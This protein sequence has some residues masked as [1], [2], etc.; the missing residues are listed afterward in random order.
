MKYA[1]LITIIL[2]S[3]LACTSNKTVEDLHNSS[4]LIDTHNDISSAG[5]VDGLDLNQDLSGKHHSDFA[6]FKEGGVDI[7]VFSI[8]MSGKEYGI[9]KAFNY[10]RRQIDTVAAHTKRN[11]D[12]LMWVTN[13]D[14]LFKAVHA[15]KMGVMLGL[16]GGY[17]I[18]DKLENLDSLFNWGVRY[19]TLTWN[20]STSWATSAADE[21]DSS[22]ILPFIGLTDFGKQ[23]VRKMNDLGI[24]VDL[25]HVGEQAFYDAIET[26]TKPVI[27]SHSCVYS[28]CPVSRN[29]KD[30]QIRAIGKNNGVIFLNFY[31]G[32]LDK[33]FK[34][35]FADFIKTHQPEYDSL[36]QSG[37][38]T[39]SAEQ[40]LAM[41][42][43]K[44]AKLIQAPVSLLVDHIDYI[45]KLIG[46]NHVGIGSDYDGIEA[47]PRNMDDVSTYPVLTKELVDRGYSESDVRKILG[48]NFIRVLKANEAN[49]EN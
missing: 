10:A 25:S 41:K 17:P 38:S 30:D 43:H 13:S 29:L 40:Y 19:I 6:R 31:S 44:E 20:E 14:E 42:Y 34:S 37:Q 22:K 39:Y 18:E 11:P 3:A 2:T 47:P 7:Q 4:I 9:G 23:I 1:L 24:M 35:K 5:L 15:K 46:I 12:N 16:E 33:N 27:A 36:L 26:S 28:I 48:E 49:I 32:F 45:V 21:T 8:W